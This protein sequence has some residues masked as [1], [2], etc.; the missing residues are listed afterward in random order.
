MFFK[1]NSDYNLTLL[2]LFG[3]LLLLLPLLRIQ[4]FSEASEGRITGP[5]F[6][7]QD[8]RPIRG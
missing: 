8:A 7:W 5:F 4:S 3:H 2:L 1:S 6:D